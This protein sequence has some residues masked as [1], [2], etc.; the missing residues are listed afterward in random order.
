MY[1]TDGVNVLQTITAS[2]EHADTSV[3]VNTYTVG[4]IENTLLTLRFTGTSAY[5]LATAAPHYHCTTSASIIYPC[6]ISLFPLM[7]C[8]SCSTL[9]IYWLQHTSE[10]G[11]LLPR[12]GFYLVPHPPSPPLRRNLSRETHRHR[13]AFDC[14]IAI[15]T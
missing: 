2:P 11:S 10:K 8:K 12:S 6:G 1:A 9:N 13:S 5:P 3:E 15:D 4:T 14:L 7:L